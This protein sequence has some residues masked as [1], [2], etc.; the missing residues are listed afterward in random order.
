MKEKTK[1]KIKRVFMKFRTEKNRL[2]HT[3]NDSDF[4]IRTIINE[5]KE[6]MTEESTKL[7]NLYWEAYKEGL[8]ICYIIKDFKKLNEGLQLVA[9]MIEEATVN[10]YIYQMTDWVHNTHPEF[11]KMR[12]DLSL[13]MNNLSTRRM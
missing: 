4:L 9:E 6:F 13:I 1:L 7:A 11:M 3:I 8:H 12:T 5:E 10:K 2:T